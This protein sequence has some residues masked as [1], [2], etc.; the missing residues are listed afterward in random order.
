[1]RPIIEVE[2]TR[3]RGRAPTSDPD[4]LARLTGVPALLWV[5]FFA[6]LS[7]CCLAVAVDWLVR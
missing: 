1:V 2:R 4:Q 6:M 7:L 3:R 5:A